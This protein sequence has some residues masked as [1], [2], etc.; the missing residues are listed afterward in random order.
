MGK[1]IFFNHMKYTATAVAVCGAIAGLALYNQG[2]T[3]QLFADNLYET[4]FTAYVAEHGKS[5]GTKEEYNFRLAQ[6]SKNMQVINQHNAADD[7]RETLGINFMADWTETEYKKLLGYK[8]NT[9]MNRS[10]SEGHPHRPHHDYH[11]HH[12]HHHPRQLEE[13]Q[14]VPASVDWRA[15]GAVTAVKNQGSCGSCWSFSA[16]GAIEGR[17]FVKSNK[18]VSLSEQ[19]LVDCST[20]LGNMGCGGGLMDYACEYAEKT[21]METE[22][23][24]PYKGSNGKCHAAGGSLEITSYKDVTPKSPSAL[25]AAAA[26]GPVAIAIDA[27]SIFF[28]LY[29]GGIMKH[30]CGTSLDHGVLLVGYGEES[31]TPFWIVKNSWGGSWGEKGYFRMLRS[32][33][34]GKPGFCGLQLQPSYP[35]M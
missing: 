17:N 2:E 10:D 15:K 19:Q 18:L 14:A 27:S 33:D 9:S 35:I 16:T 11:H 22:A 28:Q 25:M 24:Y 20:S 1:F 31:G 8:E 21:M 26:E 5:Y 12:D 23:Q 29:F 4:E 30:F 7:G 3:T 32:A 34:E 6:F 13:V